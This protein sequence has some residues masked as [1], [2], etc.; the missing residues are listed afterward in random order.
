MNARNGLGSRPD[1]A[2][3][4]LSNLRLAAKGLS[5]LGFGLGILDAAFKGKDC[6]DKFCK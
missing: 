1:A 3:R 5:K 4:S 6:Y 2:R